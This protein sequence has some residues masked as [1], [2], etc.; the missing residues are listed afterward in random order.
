[1][2][3]H[4]APLGTHERFIDFLIEHY[5]GNFPLWLAP[6]HVR[7]EG[8]YWLDPI[9]RRSRTPNRRRSTRCWSSVSASWGAIPWLCVPHGE[10]DVGVT[11]GVEALA[12]ILT[13]IPKRRVQERR[14]VPTVGR[15]EQK[16]R[17]TSRTK[18]RKTSV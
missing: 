5:A 10:G 3:I 15:D 4:R 17:N 12:D 2:C 1:M 13:T 6:D 8:D 7:A 9:D 16:V 14:G 11:P 18:S